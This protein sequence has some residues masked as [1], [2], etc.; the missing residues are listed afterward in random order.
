MFFLTTVLALPGAETEWGNMIKRSFI[1]VPEIGNGNSFPYP[2][3]N[4]CS[5]Q[6]VNML[7]KPQLVNHA[8]TL[9]TL[10]QESAAN[11]DSVDMKAMQAKI[12]QK[13]PAD[14]VNANAPSHGIPPGNLNTVAKFGSQAPVGSSTEKTKSEPQLSAD[15]LSQLSSAGQGIEDRLAAGFTSPYNLMNQLTFADQKP[16]FSATTN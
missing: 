12:N 14:G 9:A 7:M 15:Q 5:E 16:Q 2:I 8:G 4:L 1:R 6:L 10:Q 3:S 13:Y 11:V